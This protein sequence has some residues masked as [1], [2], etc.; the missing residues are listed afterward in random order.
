MTLN[1]LR[2]EFAAAYEQAATVS[3][4]L[5][6]DQLAGP[7]PCTKM[8]V[9]QLLDHLVF[10]SRRAAALGRGE[11]PAFETSA[12]HVEL[13]DAP[14]ALR[15][16]GADAAS[17]WRD[18][19]SLDRVITMPWGMEYSGRAL[20]GI[21]LVE[22]TTHSWDLAAATGNEHLL[23][24]SLG[25]SALACAEATIRPDYRN[26]AGDPF[27]PEVTAPEGATTWDRLGAFM[28]RVPR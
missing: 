16:A 25:S 6:P 10:A 4:A 2:P 5:R 23:D 7:T 9:S 18:E 14:A 26:E 22:I 20:L 13:G 3:A 28:G 15:A 12:P 24:Q 17:S 21:Y 8:D 27:G 19:A 11:V 1:D